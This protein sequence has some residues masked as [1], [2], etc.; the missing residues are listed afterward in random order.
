M[1]HEVKNA[2]VAVKTFSDLLTEKN[3]DV[4]LADT[5]RREVRRIEAIVSQV[6]KFSRPSATANQ[7]THLHPLLDRCLQGLKPHLTS[8]RL[9]LVTR[10][11]AQSDLI[12]GDEPHLEQA[13]IN[14]ILNAAEAVTGDGT[15]TVETD[16]ETDPASPSGKHPIRVTIRDTGPGIAAEDMA[17]L[18]EPFFSTKPQGTGLGLAITRRIIHEHHGVIRAESEPGT[19]TAFHILLPAL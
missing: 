7:P 18:F 12:Y 4:E 13:I 15:I 16:N 2:L 19:G 10:F 8:R 9:T 5:V 14:L 1:A 17:R 11:G 3:Q 6:L